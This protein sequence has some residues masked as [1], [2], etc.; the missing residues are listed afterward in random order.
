MT[1][2]KPMNAYPKR[3]DVERM[4]QPMA[5]SPGATPDALE[6]AGRPWRVVGADGSTR[7]FDPDG[8]GKFLADPL[9]DP[10]GDHQPAAGGPNV[11]MPVS[12]P[13]ADEMLRA[14]GNVGLCDTPDWKR[15][16]SDP[17]PHVTMQNRRSANSPLPPQASGRCRDVDSQ[18]ARIIDVWPAL[19]RPIRMAMLAMI[20]TVKGEV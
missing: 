9:G 12:T 14:A 15:V 5:P 3:D 2:N 19:P 1:R 16:E 20:E 4:F 18:L 6:M 11:E 17:A 7:S 10:L 13:A 8:P